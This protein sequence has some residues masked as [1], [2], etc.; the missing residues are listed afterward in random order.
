MQAFLLALVLTLLC[1]CAA[2]HQPVEFAPSYTL[3]PRGTLTGELLWERRKLEGRADLSPLEK[4]RLLALY[5]SEIRT[6]KVG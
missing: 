5:E 6:L 3:K 1:Q 4:K 2:K